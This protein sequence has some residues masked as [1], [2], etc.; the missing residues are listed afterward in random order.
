M[1]LNFHEFDSLSFIAEL[2][3]ARRHGVQVPTEYGYLEDALRAASC[4][5]VGGSRRE[6]S[7]ARSQSNALASVKTRSTVL[8]TA[9]DSH[10]SG[11]D[12][13]SIDLCTS[14]NSPSSLYRTL[15]LTLAVFY[16]TRMPVVWQHSQF[17]QRHH[18]VRLSIMAGNQ[19][20]RPA[21][22]VNVNLVDGS[23]PPN[24]R[25]ATPA[26]AWWQPR[27]WR[28]KPQ[29]SATIGA[30]ILLTIIVVAAV[31]GTRANRY[32]RHN[33]LSYALKESCMP[34]MIQFI[35]DRHALIL[36]PCRPREIL[37]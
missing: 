3:E 15:A 26:E 34:S 1:E 12:E 10:L 13:L 22:N 8:V 14:T 19:K 33:K 30:T 37:L 36:W 29:V 25:A 5:Q 18:F 28:F 17:L 4:F 24:R 6:V 16:P 31:L 2:F 20:S 35:G 7:P 11:A 27:N 21:A 23:P 9:S 32:P